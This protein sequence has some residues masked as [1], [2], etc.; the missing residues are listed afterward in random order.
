M[1]KSAA[2]AVL[3]GLIGSGIQASR[4]P[5]L[6]EHEVTLRV[7]ATYTD[8]LTLTHLGSTSRRCRTCSN[9]LNVWATPG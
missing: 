1:S 9:P 6:H 4:S 3:A 5:T 2:N 8:S 7:F